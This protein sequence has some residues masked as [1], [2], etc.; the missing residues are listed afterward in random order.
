MELLIVP[1]VILIAVVAIAYR[2]PLAGLVL[3]GGLV[4]LGLGLYAACP[5]QPH[6]AHGMTSYDFYS[7][8]YTAAFFT[9]IVVGFFALVGRGIKR[10]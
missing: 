6:S 1:L 4:L 7:M 3:A 10:K 8:G 5:K 9:A 2:F